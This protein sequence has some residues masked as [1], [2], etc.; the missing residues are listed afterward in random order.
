MPGC[1]TVLFTRVPATL[2]LEV[3]LPDCL[4]SAQLVPLYPCPTDAITQTFP[5]TLSSQSD[6]YVYWGLPHQ[7]HKRLPET[8]FSKPRARQLSMTW[9]LSST[10][11]FISSISLRLKSC[12]T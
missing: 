7:G 4:L 9:M 12:S 8:A 3:R 5:V 6:Q 1:S 2:W 11:L 10:A